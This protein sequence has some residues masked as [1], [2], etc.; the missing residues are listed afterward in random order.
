M[1]R[2][3]GA[4][5][6]GLGLKNKDKFYSFEEDLHHHIRE[7]IMILSTGSPMCFFSN[8]FVKEWL[9]RLDPKHRPVYRVKLLRIIRCVVDVLQNEVTLLVH[10]VVTLIFISTSVSLTTTTLDYFLFTDE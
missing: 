1:K 3:G 7:A 10:Y 2:T 8:P 4:G 6:Q 5:P 9:K